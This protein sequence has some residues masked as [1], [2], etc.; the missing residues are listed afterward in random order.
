MI[1][2]YTTEVTH[3][4][5]Y[6]LDT[7]FAEYFGLSYTLVTDP[8]QAP[9]SGIR[10]NYSGEPL[11]G[12]FS[13]SRS[14][15]LFETGIRPQH[16]FISRIG[17]MPVIFQDNGP[18]DLSF[19][20]F[21]AVFYLLSRYEE[22]L[23][24]EQDGHGRYLASNSILSNPVFDFAPVAETWLLYL[25]TR[26]LE[27]DP[28]LP[29]LQH[30]KAIE[31]T[32]DIDQ[33][34]AYKG[35]RWP[36]ILGALAKRE[37]QRVLLQGKPDPYDTI[38]RILDFLRT[39]PVSAHF[40]FLMNDRG[41]YNSSVDPNSTR[42]GGYIRQCAGL[43]EVGI[44]PSY[45]AFRD[46]LL[47]PERRLLESCLNKPLTHSRQHFLRISF[48][49]YYRWL[50]NQG[51]IHDHSLGYPDTPGFRAG[52]SRPFR[53]YDLGEERDTALWLHP[54]CFMDATYIYYKQADTSQI[55]KKFLGISE[56]VS[57]VNGKLVT[58]SHNDLLGDYC[59]VNFWEVLKNCAV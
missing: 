25:K 28:A 34:F 51:I 42:L 15:L 39:N 58:V 14:S 23:P 9:A 6:T 45:E 16:P 54:F 8:D 44:H 2:I 18:A 27:L 47:E 29:F 57:K 41:D 20:V 50:Q 49:A 33:A 12:W 24:H 13:V 30:K 26:L 46:D 35:R 32:F 36:K 31:C 17:D 48:P 4:L 37:G 11:P 38:P 53:F 56:Q 40:F 7:V 5:R 52:F 3:R 1:V 19:D 55:I 21:A 22:Y 59:P 43:A 10:I